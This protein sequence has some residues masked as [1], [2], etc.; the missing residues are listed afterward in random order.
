VDISDGRFPSRRQT[1]D[2][3]R[4]HCLK[5]NAAGLNFAEAASA[6]AVVSM[7]ALHEMANPPAVLQEVRRVL[8]PGGE[9]FIV[10][11]P[12]DSLA[13][14]LW[15]EK[16]LRPSELKVLLQEA[17]FDQVRVGTIE[18]GEVMWARGYR[19]PRRWRPQEQREGK[20]HGGRA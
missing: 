17:G 12:R 14:R 13:Q 10:D 3:A 7:W 6:D 20:S 1:S 19:R 11:Y 4:Y 2:G 15:N 9:V 5:R 16:Y 8:R 18:Q